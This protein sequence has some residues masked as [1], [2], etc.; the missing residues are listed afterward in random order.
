MQGRKSGDG[1]MTDPIL[2]QSSIFDLLLKEPIDG[3]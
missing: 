1:N 2:Q 3:I